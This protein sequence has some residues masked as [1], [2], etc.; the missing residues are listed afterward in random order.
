LLTGAGSPTGICV[1]EGTLLPK[2]F[3]NQMIHCDAGPSVCRAYP[4]TKNGAGYKADTVNVLAGTRDNWFRPSDVC[5][6]P[7]GSL[8]VADWYDPG[9]GSHNQQRLI[10]PDLPRRTTGAK[11]RVPKYDYSTAQAL[12][13]LKASARCG[14]WHSRRCWKKERTRPGLQGRISSR[15]IR[16]SR[17]FDG[18]RATYSPRLASRN[19]ENGRCVLSRSIPTCG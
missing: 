12:A 8:F 1:Y 17:P 13:A 16:G 15:T 5:V 7:D 3:Q 11:C 14:I 6:A 19:V 2:V 10:R 9:V 4:V 18:L